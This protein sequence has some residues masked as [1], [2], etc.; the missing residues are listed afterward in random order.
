MNLTLELPPG[1][2][3]LAGT[4]NTVEFELETENEKPFAGATDPATRLI[5]ITEEFPPTTV[6]GVAVTLP[7]AGV[8]ETDPVE[9]TNPANPGFAPMIGNAISGRPSRLKSPVTSVPPPTL[10]SG[11]G[12]A[13]KT[14]GSK[15]PSPFPVRIS[16]KPSVP[17]ARA[18]ARS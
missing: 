10:E 9:F 1:M 8:T 5:V 2:K 6:E 11:G 16:N 3:T 17:F 13:Y 12:A 15:V 7:Y 18:S 4:C 14:G